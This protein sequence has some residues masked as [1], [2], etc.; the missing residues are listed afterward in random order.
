MKLASHALEDALFSHLASDADLLAL[1]S[2]PAIYREPR[3][4]R[5][6]PYLTLETLASRDWDTS[7]DFG[8]DHRLQIHIWADGQARSQVQIILARLMLILREAELI[9][10]D[11]QLVNLRVRSSEIMSERKH[12]LLHGVMQIRAVT[13]ERPPQS[14]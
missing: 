2:G 13:E 1:L 14:A 5:S 8:Q 11:H 4:N 12:R 3:R 9:L 6:F 10:V 7:S